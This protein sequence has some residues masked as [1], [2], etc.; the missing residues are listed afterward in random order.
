L[1]ILILGGYGTFGGRLAQLLADEPRLTLVIAGRSREKAA[2]FCA[3]LPAGASQEP[4]VFDRDGDVADQLR[5]LAPD[6]VVDATGPFQLYGDDPYRVVKAALALGISYLDLAD[7]SAFVKGIAPFDDAARASGVFILSGVSSFPVLTAAVVR[8]LSRGMQGLDSVTGGIA[9][10]PYAGV[11]INVIRA[12]AGY[13]GKPVRLTRDGKPATGYALAETLRYTIAPPG[14]LPLKSLRFSLVDVPDLQVLPDLWTSLRSV[15]ISAGP[16]PASLHR[17]L[18][19]LAWTVRLGLV[20]SL[21]SFAGLF[22]RVINLL[23]W[24]EHR[25]GMFVAI[26]GRLQDGTAIERSWHLVAEGDDG[27]LIPSMAAEAIIRHCLDGRRPAAG[28][29]PAATDLELRDYDALFARR[30]IYWGCREATPAFAGLP[31]YR[32][33]LGDAWDRL[34]EPIRAMHDFRD[35]LTTTSMATIERGTSWPARLVARLFGFP[36]AG[37]DVPV[38]VTFRGRDDAEIWQRSFADRSFASV[39]SAGRGRF[40]KLIAERF[41]PFVFGLALVLEEDRLRLVLRR[42]SFLGIPL[43]MWLAPRGD[44]HEHAD[45][46]R[47]NFHVEISHPLMGLIVRYRGWLTLRT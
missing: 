30:R 23:R 29:R 16:V 45:P 11:G 32:R 21:S 39:Q 25:G 18:N 13:A 7:G 3:G 17:A 40:D 41:G 28:A 26:K 9:P 27:P 44:S 15:W 10:S 42:W 36:Q 47:F 22:Y 12:I 46:G 33:I 34:P 19:L 5:R 1:K 6:V 31:L 35:E 24:G 43:P 4:A 8:A 20:P 37:R 14:R 2:A 38:T